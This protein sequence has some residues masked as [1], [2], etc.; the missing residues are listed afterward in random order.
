[1]VLLSWCSDRHPDPAPSGYVGSPTYY[2]PS[3]GEA[4]TGEKPDGTY[5]CTVT[6]I[7]QGNGPYTLQCDKEG[8]DVTVHFNNG[9]YITLDDGMDPNS[10]DQWEVEID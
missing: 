6:N 5:D 9:G 4:S 2:A 8:D 1:M 10:G 3:L 7:T